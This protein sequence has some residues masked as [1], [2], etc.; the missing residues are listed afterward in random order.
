MVSAFLTPGG[1]LKVPGNILDEELLQNPMWSHHPSTGQPVYEAFEFWEYSKDNYWN[2]ESM[3]EQTI[4]ATL[5]IFPLSLGAVVFG[6]LTMQ[7]I[8][9]PMLPMFLLLL[10]CALALEVRLNLE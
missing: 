10:E 9:M 6:L 4:R 7:Q 1:P 2:G 5:P 3:V 8:T